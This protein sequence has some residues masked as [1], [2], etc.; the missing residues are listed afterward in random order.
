MKYKDKCLDHID[1]IERVNKEVMT[2]IQEAIVMNSVSNLNKC[3]SL[4]GNNEK[5]FIEYLRNM[6]ELEEN[7]PF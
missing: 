1:S 7:P 4:L 5:Q 6:I 3:V 2:L